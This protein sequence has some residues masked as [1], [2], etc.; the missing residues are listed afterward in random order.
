M[1]VL[2]AFI[3]TVTLAT[4]ALAKPLQCNW[5]EKNQCDAGKGCRKISAGTI[6]VSLDT[7]TKEY[8]RCDRNGCDTYQANVHVSGAFTIF[9][10]AG[11]GVFA[12]VGPNGQSS[13]VVSLGNSILISHGFCR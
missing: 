6:S 4:P 9:D 13:E 12:K 2:V 10:L 1:K 11:R 8:K 7:K 5:V 3:M